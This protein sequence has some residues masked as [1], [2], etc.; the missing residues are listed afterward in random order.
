MAFKLTLKARTFLFVKAI[1]EETPLNE[2]TKG[3]KSLIVRSHIDSKNFKTTAI[4][5]IVT[6]IKRLTFF[7][8]FDH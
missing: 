4:I 3:C 2:T 7:K 8:V 6:T 1:K 5:K